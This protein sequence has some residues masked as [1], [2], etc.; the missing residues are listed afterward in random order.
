MRMIRTKYVIIWVILCM[1]VCHHDDDVSQVNLASLLCL[2]CRIFFT[3]TLIIISYQMKEK[4]G[5]CWRKRRRMGDA[6]GRQEGKPSSSTWSSLVNLSCAK[7][8]YDVLSS[9]HLLTDFL[10]N[11]RRCCRRVRNSKFGKI[12]G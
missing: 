2:C 11:N 8:Y 3:C 1:C 5:I 7:I 9:L 4:N 6:S 10:Y 12:C